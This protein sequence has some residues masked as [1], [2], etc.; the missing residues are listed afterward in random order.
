[1][2]TLCS[3]IDQLIHLVSELLNKASA[4]ATIWRF[5]NPISSWFPWFVSAVAYPFPSSD[6]VGRTKH[7]IAVFSPW[8]YHLPG[9]G[10][11]SHVWSKTIVS[12]WLLCHTVNPQRTSSYEQLLN[13]FS[14]MHLKKKPTWSIMHYTFYRKWFVLDFPS[15][16]IIS[17]HSACLLGSHSCRRLSLRPST[18]ASSH[19]SSALLNSLWVWLYR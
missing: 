4:P 18:R 13:Q 7:I 15:Q 1:M 3:F 17:S 5:S 9:S 2:H 10:F 19:G 8:Q 6:V 11:Y 14:F 12:F 16:C